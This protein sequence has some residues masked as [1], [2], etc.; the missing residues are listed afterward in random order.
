MPSI[1]TRMQSVVQLSNCNGQLQD[2]ACNEMQTDL[3]ISA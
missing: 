3:P 2:N 1:T